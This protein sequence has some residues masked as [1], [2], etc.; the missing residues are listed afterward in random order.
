MLPERFGRYEVLAEIGDGAMGRVYAAWDPAVSRKVAVKTVKKGIGQAWRDNDP[1]Y[2]QPLVSNVREVK[3]LVKLNDAPVTGTT[4]SDGKVDL[5]AKGP[6]SGDY[7]HAVYAYVVRAVNR[8]GA[9]SG[10]SPYALTIPSEP[11]NVLVRNKDGGAWELR[12]DA[13][14]EKGISGYRV[15]RTVGQQGLMEPLTPEAVKATRFEGKGQGRLW[16]TAVDGLGQEGQPSSPA[17]VQA[18]YAGHVA[19]EWHQ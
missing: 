18:S 1:E 15:Y 16:V 13:N 8:L 19:G 17:N 7:S 10:L 9:E 12:W 11:T 2:P 14:P 4:F 6:E 5:L 3:D